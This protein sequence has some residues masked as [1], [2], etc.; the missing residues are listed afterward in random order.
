[1]IL[2]KQKV[3]ALLEQLSADREVFVPVVINGVAKFARFD[4]SVEPD[5]SLFNTTMPPK[6]LLFPQTQKMYRFDVDENGGYIINEY[7]ESHE[8]VV[9]GIRPCDMR[10]IVC[11]DEVFLTRGLLLRFHGH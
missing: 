10:S 6:D 9:F 8:Q 1:M 5:F 11:L 4:K 3:A 7:D 2:N